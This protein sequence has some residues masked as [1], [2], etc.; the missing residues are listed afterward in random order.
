[1]DRYGIDSLFKKTGL[2]IKQHFPNDKLFN[3]IYYNRL[4]LQLHSLSIDETDGSVSKI[5]L[6]KPLWIIHQGQI[7][8]IFWKIRKIGFFVQDDCHSATIKKGIV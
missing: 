2:C 4:C 3:L 8:L 6:G 5:G 7:S 1:M